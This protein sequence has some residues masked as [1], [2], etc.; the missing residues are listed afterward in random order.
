M[1][2]KKEET[3]EKNTCGLGLGK[4]FLDDVPQAR[5]IKEQTHKLDCIET[6]NLLF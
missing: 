1:K 6:K 4:D 5:S 2:T 3:Q